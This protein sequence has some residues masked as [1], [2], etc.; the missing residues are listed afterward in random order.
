MQA[1]TILPTTITIEDL[2][3]QDRISD[4]KIAIGSID[5]IMIVAVTTKNFFSFI[6]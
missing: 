1:K 5:N 3:I 6:L 2:N 4:Y